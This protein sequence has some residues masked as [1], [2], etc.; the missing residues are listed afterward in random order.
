[1]TIQTEHWHARTI[2]NRLAIARQESPRG[3]EAVCLLSALGLIVTAAI[4]ILGGPD[5]VSA[6]N[7]AATLGGG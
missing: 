3:F 6:F 7:L 1:M 4:L 5:V 2:E